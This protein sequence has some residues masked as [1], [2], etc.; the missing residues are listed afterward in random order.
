[1]LCRADSVGVFQVGVRAQMATLPRLRPRTFYDLVVEVALIR[2][3]PIQGGSVHPYIRRRNGQEPVT[4][5]HPLLENS[6]GQDPRGAAVPG[7]A[8]ADGHRRG[9]LHPRRGRPAAPGHGLQAQP[10][11]DGAAAGAALRR[12]GRAGHHG[13]GG[14]RDLRQDGGL[15]QLRL[16]REPLGARSPT[17]STPRPGS[18]CTSRRRSA[19]RCSTPSRWASTRP[20]RWC[21]TPAATGSWCARPTSTP[22]PRTAALEPCPESHHE[23]AVRMG[24]GP[25]GPRCADQVGDGPG[26]PGGRP[27]APR[28]VPTADLEDL[29]R[30][31]PELRLAPAGGL[32]TAGAFGCFGLERREALWAVGAAVPSPGP[33]GW[34]GW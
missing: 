18:S 27:V 34:R 16:P 6:A 17:S 22:P 23:V 9:R 8:H 2:P 29:V 15:R 24:L 14:R 28:A 21:R 19:R 11:A 12:H 25:S 4:Y 20:T 32:A 7:A 13:R 30:R 10:G 33:T 5:L 1:M 26:R 3:G 31:V